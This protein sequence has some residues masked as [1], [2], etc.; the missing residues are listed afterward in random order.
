MKFGVFGSIRAEKN[1]VLDLIPVDIVS[2]SVIVAGSMNKKNGNLKVYNCTSGSIN[3]ITFGKYFDVVQSSTVCE[4]VPAFLRN[5]FVINSNY[6]I[7][8]I[9]RYCFNYFSFFLADLILLIRGQE[10]KSIQS[11]RKFYEGIDLLEYFAIR[12]WNFEIENFQK[13]IENSKNQEGNFDCDIKSLKW[14]KFAENSVEGINRYF[15]QKKLSKKLENTE[16]LTSKSF[17]IYNMK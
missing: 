1:I 16:I 14:D 2:K 10:M 15:I 3:P 9:N 12:D 7:N 11:A 17:K 6:L 5:K 13:L 8:R 4:G